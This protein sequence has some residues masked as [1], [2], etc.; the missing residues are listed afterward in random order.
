VKGSRAVGRKIF[1]QGGVAKNHSVGYAFAQ[2]TGKQI[3]I[4]PNPELMGAYGVALITKNKYEMHDI[5][6]MPDDTTLKTLTLKELEHLGSFQCKGCNNYCKIERYK[7]GNRKFAFGGSCSKYEN[8]WRRTKQN[9]EKEDVVAKR[10]EIFFGM[11]K[12]PKLLSILR[13]KGKIGIPRALLTHSLY[14]LYSTFLRE[15]G[16][17]VVLSDIDEDMELM[18]NAPFCYPVQ[19]MHGAVL[20]LL[21]KNISTIFIPHVVNMTKGEDWLEATFCPITQASSYF[22]TTAFKKADI[23]KPVVDFSGGYESETALIKLAVEKLGQPRGLAKEAFQ[24]AT[25]IQKSIENR[26]IKMGNEIIKSLEDKNETGIVLVGRSYNAFPPET[27]MKISKKLASMGITVIPFDFLEKDDVKDLPWYFANYV[28]TA[29]NLVL[30]KENLFLLYINSF[31]C[32]I[33]AFIQN[34]VRTEMKNKPY[35]ILELDAHTADAG[36]QTRLEAFLEI[37]KNHQMKRQLPKQK[38]FQ[39][40]KVKRRNGETFVITSNGKKL[41]LRDSRVKLYLPSFSKYHTDIGKKLLELFNFNTCESTD[42]KLEYPVKGLRYSSGKEC[43]PLP[44]ILGQIMSIVEKRE[45]G[46]VVGIYIIRGGS[47]CAVFSYYHYIEQFIENNQLEDVF[48]F[49]FDYPTHYLGLN[50]PEVLRYFPPCFILG[51]IINEIDSA[52]QVVGEKDSVRLLR[53]YWSAFLESMNDKKDFKNSVAELSSRIATIPRKQSPKHLPKVLISGDFFVRFSPFFLKELKKI[54][55]KNDILVKSSDL[56]ELG[57]YG[58]HFNGGYIVT[59]EWK[60][61][62]DKVTTMLRAS[63]T[64]WNKGSQLLLMSKAAVGIMQQMEK[65]MRNQFEKTGLLFAQPNDLKKIINLSSEWISRL[66][67]GEA[68]PT[69]GKGLETLEDSHFDSLILTGPFNC[70]PYKI[71]QAIL[72][73]IYME[74]NVPFLV[75]DADIS[76]ITPNERRLIQ[77]NIEQIKRRNKKKTKE[78]RWMRKVERKVRRFERKIERKRKKLEVKQERKRQRLERRLTRKELKLERKM[79]QMERKH[80]RKKNKLLKRIK[81]KPKEIQIQEKEKFERT[82]SRKK[83]RFERKIIRKERR[84]ERK[85]IKLENRLSRKK[86]RKEQRWA[87]RRERKRNRLIRRSKIKRMRWFLQFLHREEEHTKEIDQKH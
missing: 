67:F 87:R 35:L 28:K 25:G 82:I 81:D 41:D 19:I 13:S 12:E 78:A 2:A 57:I 75:F 71:S 62:P 77:A 30:K 3:I 68:I 65:R 14:P 53:E 66:I 44:V 33:D 45:P 49:R 26:F 6:A 80:E 58:N 23:L 85:R 5:E 18:T 40:A 79:V 1:F 27:S 21:K 31:S 70:L 8:Q 69:I 39:V 51:D 10:N 52:L 7:V 47:P 36:I 74:E 22:I 60:K 37:I 24:K 50:L 43:I 29:I 55:A 17:E 20:D 61:N 63:V 72:K 34:Y 38:E 73:P 56:F 64:P 48:L 83:Q 84:Y 46:E 86:K 16:Y 9:K 76:S 59:K 4:P 32:T 15:L 11:E 54:Y 42:I